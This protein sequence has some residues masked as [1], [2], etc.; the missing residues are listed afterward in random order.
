MPAAFS[1]EVDAC[2]KET[3]ESR[4]NT[5]P[6]ISDHLVAPAGGSYVTKPKTLQGALSEIVDR[7]CVAGLSIWFNN[8]CAWQHVRRL[9]GCLNVMS[10]PPLF[11]FGVGLSLLMIQW[12]V[13]I[14]VRPS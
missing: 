1:I 12:Y 7:S 13:R 11:K 5:L 8:E 10:V 4:G 3:A 6:D 14:V 2:L 9:I